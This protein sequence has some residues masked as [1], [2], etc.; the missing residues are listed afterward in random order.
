MIVSTE[1]RYIESSV[2]DRTILFQG[3]AVELHTHEGASLS[4]A[5]ALRLLPSCRG[6]YYHPRLPR[7]TSSA[8]YQVSVAR[9]RPHFVN[10]TEFTILYEVEYIV[11]HESLSFCFMAAR[12][13]LRRKC[14]KSILHVVQ[15]W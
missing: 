12:F 6:V 15:S 4:S 3:V 14:R 7:G 1:G 10:F 8:L 9:S 5:S 13:Y 2:I 11:S